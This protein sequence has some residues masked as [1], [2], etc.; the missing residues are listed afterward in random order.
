MIASFG[1][2]CNAAGDRLFK[3]QDAEA[4]EVA[5]DNLQHREPFRFDEIGIPVRPRGYP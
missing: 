2:P 4:L 1:Q 5:G 3:R